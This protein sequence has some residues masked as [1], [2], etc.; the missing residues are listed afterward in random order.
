MHYT[1]LRTSTASWWLGKGKGPR[2]GMYTPY[3]VLVPT[4]RHPDCQK[5]SPWAE[6]L[7]L[8]LGSPP[9]DCCTLLS[10][11]P[12]KPADT[13]WLSVARS[14]W[15]RECGCKVGA[16]QSRLTVPDFVTA[17]GSKLVH[18]Q[19]EPAHPYRSSLLAQAPP[20]I[21]HL[22]LVGTAIGLD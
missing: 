5:G 21:G 9:E 6:L 18:E 14:F 13:G 16:G 3:S 15:D 19:D 20:K 11:R 8:F 1:M 22:K 12:A 7:L 2:L 17:G 10:R 4:T